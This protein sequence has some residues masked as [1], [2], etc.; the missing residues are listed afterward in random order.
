MMSNLVIHSFI[1]SFNQYLHAG[2]VSRAVLNSGAMSQWAI[3][4]KI[5][6]LKLIGIGI[7]VL[8][9]FSSSKRIP[10]LHWLKLPFDFCPITRSLL[11][12][13]RGLDHKG[14]HLCCASCISLLFIISWYPD[15]SEGRRNVRKWVGNGAVG[16][17][18]W[19]M[20]GSVWD[21]LSQGTWWCDDTQHTCPGGN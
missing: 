16:G 19:W 10:K 8:N 20:T 12:V 13:V 21:M 7:P 18:L 3:L 1:H 14:P 11:P 5:L 2:H 15:G 4:E 17:G 6:A 9:A